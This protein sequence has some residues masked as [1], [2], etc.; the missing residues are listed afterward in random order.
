MRLR[1]LALMTFLLAPAACSAPPPFE[2]QG[3]CP[4]EPNCGQCASRGGCGWCGDQCMAVGAAA[5]SSDWIKTPG[6]CPEPAT[7]KP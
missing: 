4:K 7:I 2:A 3:D 5:C 1:V 6:E